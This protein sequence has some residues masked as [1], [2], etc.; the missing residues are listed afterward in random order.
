MKTKSVFTLSMHALR[1]HT[2]ARETTIVATHAPTQFIYAQKPNKACCEVWGYVLP[3]NILKGS[4]WKCKWNMISTSDSKT[5][6]L[7]V[8]AFPNSV[9]N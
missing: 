2:Q 8:Q 1:A 6:W 9:D 7:G 4:C 5:L 3:A